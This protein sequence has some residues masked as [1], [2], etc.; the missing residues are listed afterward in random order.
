M[1]TT[2]N[3][4]SY[5][6]TIWFF[7]CLP[8]MRKAVINSHIWGFVKIFSLL[9]FGVYVWYVYMCMH[10]GQRRMSGVPLYHSLPDACETV[11]H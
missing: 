10:E 11:S 6:R 5:C 1:E 2:N 7:L 4:L 8:I 9:V 3:F